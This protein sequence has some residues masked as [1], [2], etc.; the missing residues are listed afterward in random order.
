[1]SCVPQTL[2]GERL[3]KKSLNLSWTASSVRYEKNK[4]LEK[5]S[6]FE[7]HGNVKLLYEFLNTYSQ[8]LYLLYLDQ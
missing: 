7:C 4:S 1:M 6:Q 8:F 2:C 5:V 3:K